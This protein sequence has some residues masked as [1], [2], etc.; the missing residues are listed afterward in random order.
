MVFLNRKKSDKV[1][2]LKNQ[3]MNHNSF[4]NWFGWICGVIGGGLH[5]TLLEIHIH[6]ADWVAFARACITAVACGFAGMAGKALWN[7]IFK[8]KNQ[9]NG[10][11]NS[12]T[13]D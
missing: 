8:I 12:N 10:K 5:Y 13:P 2:S 11:H 9:D 1:I 6:E 3:N 4:D 7:R